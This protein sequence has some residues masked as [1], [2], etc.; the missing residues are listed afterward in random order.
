MQVYNTIT[1][2]K[3]EFKTHKPGAVSMYACGIT[4]YDYSHIGHARSSVVFDVISR[5]LRFLNY[6]VTFVRNFTDID[7]K[8]INRANQE[9]VSSE[10]I[11]EK[12]IKA[13]HE[14]M[15][16]LYV[17]R[18]DIEPKAT[19]YIPEMIDI[20]ERLIAK[21]HAYPTNTGDVNFRV[22]SF[23]EYGKLSGRTLEDMQAGA[24]VE[25]DENKENPFDFVLWKAAK[26]NEPYWESPW[27]KGRPGWHIECS[28]M[29]ER[30]LELPLDIHGGGQDLIFP[31]HENEIAQSEAALGHTFANYW[32][33]NGFVQINS[34]KMS[35]SLNNFKT[36]RDILENRLPE[37]L[38]FFLLT[39][40]YRSPIDFSFDALD[41]AEK[42][43]KK[44]Y[45]CI[46]LTEQTLPNLKKKSKTW[47]DSIYSEYAAIKQSFFAAMYDDFNTAAAIG[48]I[49]SATRLLNRVI[50][51]KNLVSAPEAEKLLKDFLEFTQD[52]TSILG[53]INSDAHE[54]LEKLK[55][56]HA[57]R[58]NID[59]AKV[60]E[61]LEQRKQA[62][63]DKDY[64]KSDE[65]RDTLLA[66]HVNIKDTA[67]GQAWYLD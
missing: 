19:E 51:T 9:N 10:E 3:E 27:G 20:I 47:D 65:I 58:L 45:E 56:S 29:S 55:L 23:K 39:K 34:E 40:H 30:N 67:Q 5:F 62:R 35:K 50:E 8:I 12:Y 54:F 24:R 49:F 22:N 18:A 1:R 14:D 60:E 32:M 43:L 6:N 61:L 26:A 57:K 44:I 42:S 17:Q 7:D 33:H 11:A 28:A 38:R 52:W 13:F 36:I 31:H 25:V 46:A 37:C 64:A 16:A 41:E 4:A 48:H 63:A 53:I 21:G 66:M 2:K 15:D 59:V